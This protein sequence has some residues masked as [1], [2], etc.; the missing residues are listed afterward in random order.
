[1]HQGATREGAVAKSVA[2]CA[3]HCE[4]IRGSSQELSGMSTPSP[5]NSPDAA[6]NDPILIDCHAIF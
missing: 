1:M 2:P 6:L 4:T 3:L 5:P